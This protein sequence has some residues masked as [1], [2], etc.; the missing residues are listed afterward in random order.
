MG[1]EYV[2][3]P[4]CNE[5]I[6]DLRTLGLDDGDSVRVECECGETMVIECDVIRDFS[7]EK[8]PFNE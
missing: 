3:C 8:V 4:Y 7:V 6:R 1:S 5:I 2:R